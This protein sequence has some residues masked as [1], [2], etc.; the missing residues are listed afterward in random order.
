MCVRYRFC[1]VIIESVS[2]SV[3][4]SALNRFRGRGWEE[5]GSFC[6]IVEIMV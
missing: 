1:W 4:V 5:F 6:F 3:G 2:G